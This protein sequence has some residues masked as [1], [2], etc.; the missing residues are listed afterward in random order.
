MRTTSILLTIALLIPVIGNLLFAFQFYFM[1][2]HR[3]F[4]KVDNAFILKSYAAPLVGHFI[5]IALAMILNIKQK[6][7][8]NIIMCATIVGSYILFVLLNFGSNFLF[9]WLR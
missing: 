4:G 8:E 1:N 5:F 2:S 3:M 7:Y 9:N 6:Y